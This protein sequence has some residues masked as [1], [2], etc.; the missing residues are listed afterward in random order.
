MADFDEMTP[1][2]AATIRARM[3][4]DW[5]AR[6]RHYATIAAARN[7]AFAEDLVAV[8]APQPGQRV[9]DVATGPGVAALA[10]ARAVGPAGRVLA[11]DLVPEFGAIVAAES[12]TAAVDNVGFRAMGA[13]ELALPDQ[14]F[15]VVL[16]QFGLMFIPDPV[17]ALGE[18]RRVLRPGGR[19]GV[20][21]WSVPEKVDHFLASRILTRLVPPAPEAERMPTPLELS[22]PGRIERL[23]A[24]A[25]FGGVAT[26][27]VTHEFV[28]ADPE[29]EWRRLLEEP[30]GPIKRA[31]GLLS[32][33]AVVAAHDQVI[34]AFESR[35]RSDGEIR[36]SSEAVIVT[37]VR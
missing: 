33:A 2:R 15:D 32:A 1:E 20:S 36:L 10:A 9:L 37:A 27:V 21:V 6:A 3:R 30:T 19:L 25:G 16:C 28:I 35:R 24:A 14:S 23:V 18:M 22:E 5:G 8:V 13:E 4:L 17:R 11:T 34:A 7:A 31:F 12:I 29:A 26:T